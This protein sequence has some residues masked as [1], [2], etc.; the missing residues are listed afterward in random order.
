[1]YNTESKRDVLFTSPIYRDKMQITKEHFSPFA[2]NNFRPKMFCYI[3]D[4]HS[5]AL[6]SFSQK[7]EHIHIA[8]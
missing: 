4:L 5:S 7:Q 2:N 3:S 8:A 1:M 6:E